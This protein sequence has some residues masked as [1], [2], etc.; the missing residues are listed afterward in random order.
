MSKPPNYVK[1]Y[2]QYLY[3]DI[4]QNNIGEYQTDCPFKNCRKENHL[5][6]NTDTGLWHCKKCDERGNNQTLVTKLH[7]EALAETSLKQLKFISNLR[8]LDLKILELA[9]FAYDDIFDRWYVPYK[10]FDIGKRQFSPFLNNLGIFYPSLSNPREQ[11]V[12][13]KGSSFTAQ[14]YNPGIH[15]LDVDIENAY[16]QEGEWD[17]LAY[18]EHYSDRYALGKPGSGFTKTAIKALLKSSNIFT[19]LDNDMGGQKQTNQVVEILKSETRAKIF[20]LNWPGIEDA[21][22]DIRDLHIQ[23][24]IHEIEDNFI[25]MEE[26]RQDIHVKMDREGNEEEDPASYIRSTSDAPPVYT[27]T[28]YITGMKKCNFELSTKTHNAALALMAIPLTTHIGGVP[29][30]TFLRGPGSSGKTT[31]VDS[32]GGENDLFDCLSKIT[33]ESLVSGFRDDEGLTT[34]YLPLLINKTLII[35][36]FTVTLL[37]PPDQ[38]N[39]V[40][41]ILTDIYDGRVKIHYG[42]AKMN[43][44]KNTH[45][46]MIACV[47]P[48]IDGFSASNIGDRFLR[49]DWLGDDTDRATFTKNAIASLNKE[50]EIDKRNLSLM[51]LGYL[52]HQMSRDID[53]RMDDTTINTLQQLADFTATLST[54]VVTD[55]HDGLKFKPEPQL[56][57]RIGKQLGKIYLGVRH[58]VGEDKGMEVARKVAFDSSKGFGLEIVKHIMDNKFTTR[59]EI[60][61]HVGISSSQAHRLVGELITMNIL[62]ESRASQGTSGRPML[63]YTINDTLMPALKHD[64]YSKIRSNLKSRPD[65][66]RLVPPRRT[67]ATS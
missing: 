53:T 14:L 18:Y 3:I 12:I 15:P 30:W 56:G 22:K 19:M 16:V 33:A 41:G 65:V 59:N 50:K 1:F 23:D 7:E 34:S 21:P 24:R 54:K 64:S 11:F 47:T 25:I 6:V 35:K 37:S 60:A 46:N 62:K 43:D 27:Y 55:R 17:N 42:N 31:Y 52:K 61:A 39:K 48:L 8:K 9:Q 5:Y 36:D 38:L 51:T 28:E 29:V 4:P 2:N 49:I 20:A 40:M 67:K 13:R 66:P 10:T 45:F 57:A 26:A 58:M 44:F 63:V 32:F